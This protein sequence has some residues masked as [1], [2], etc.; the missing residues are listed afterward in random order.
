MRAGSE[1]NRKQNKL[2]LMG[3]G[4]LYSQD[5]Q[6]GQTLHCA[7]SGHHSFVVTNHQQVFVLLLNRGLVLTVS[8]LGGFWIM[9]SPSNVKE[10]SQFATSLSLA[11]G[12]PP[13]HRSI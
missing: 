6:S 12:L 9:V 4:S 1:S 13:S 8:L 7:E 2:D 10:S 5:L 11:G 3:L